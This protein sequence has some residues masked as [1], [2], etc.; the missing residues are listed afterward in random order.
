MSNLEIERKK[1]ELKRVTLSKDEME[2]KILERLADIDRLKENIA[3]QEKR[4]KELQQE[5]KG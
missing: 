4:I 1:I 3:V 2:F 5:T